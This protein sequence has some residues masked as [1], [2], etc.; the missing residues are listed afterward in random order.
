MKRIL[1]HLEA[2]LNDRKITNRLEKYSG[3]KSTLKQFSYIFSSSIRLRAG[4]MKSPKI[5]RAIPHCG[6]PAGLELSSGSVRT[7][8]QTE[9][10]SWLKE[11]GLGAYS[12]RIQNGECL[13]G[14]PEK[15]LGKCFITLS[16]RYYVIQYY[17]TLHKT[18]IQACRIH[19]TK[20]N[21]DW[22][23]EV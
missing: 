21:C 4:D 18:Q 19:F 8:G 20:R 12:T 3:I 16:Y 13:L 15:S 1:E 11:L 23:F 14:D 17:V 6:Q 22:L 7:W 9:T 5:S 2:H 10:I